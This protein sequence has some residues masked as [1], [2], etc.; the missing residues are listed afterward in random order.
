M[1]W[2]VTGISFHSLSPLTTDTTRQVFDGT[3]FMQ[4]RTLG[5][6]MLKDQRGVCV[7]GSGRVYVC[8]NNSS[9]G[10]VQAVVVLDGASGARLATIAVPGQPLGV[11]VTRSSAIVV[12]HAGPNGMVVVASA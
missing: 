4:L 2:F 12:T 8:D 7:D 3:T 1:G 6:G 11:T 5:A 9:T 10:S